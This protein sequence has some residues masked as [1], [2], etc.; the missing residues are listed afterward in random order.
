MGQSIPKSQLWDGRVLC[1]GGPLPLMNSFCNKRVLWR[2]PH[3]TA[4]LSQWASRRNAQFGE[5]VGGL[6][7]PPR[8][9][10]LIWSSSECLP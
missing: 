2:M 9:A 5:P 10:A 7:A 8:A 1:F 3:K 6:Q 4:V